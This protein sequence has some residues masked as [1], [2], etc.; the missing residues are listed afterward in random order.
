MKT[1]KGGLII[2]SGGC[3]ALVWRYAWANFV[4]VA[5]FHRPFPLF[6]AIVAFG[7]AAI[8][9]SVSRGRGWR[10][11]QVL[12]LQLTGF[13]LA[14]L[15][16]VYGFHEW[17]HP[18]TGTDWLLECLHSTRGPQEWLSLVLLLCWTFL[19]WFGGVSLAKKPKAYLAV[20]ARFDVGV[21][22][23]FALFLTKLL[24]RF[25]GGPA[26]EEPLSEIMLLP[27]FLFGLLAIGLARSQSL[28]QRGFL[29]GYRGLGVALS[30][31]A[32]VLLFGAG[33]VLLFYPYLTVAAEAG[34]GVLKVAARPMVPVLV[35]ILRFLFTPRYHS[36]SSSGAD[37]PASG[38]ATDPGWWAGPTGEVVRILLL[39]SAVLALLA[40][41]CLLLW[42]LFKWLLS[43]TPAR[44]GRSGG[45]S[46][47]SRLAEIWETI[48]G[49][50]RAV[51]G[52]M[53]NRRKGSVQ[54]YAAM[55]GWGRRSGVP[56]FLSETP[57]EYGGRLT[58]R[59]PDLGRDIA[60]IVEVFNREVYGGRKAEGQMLAPAQRAWAHLQSPLHWPHRFKAWFLQA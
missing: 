3:V 17:S 24:I 11:I 53:G 26:I 60:S 29:S 52:R 33:L 56:R 35:G 31:S 32:V 4:T 38:V 44:K 57:M 14:F 5:A 55:L 18:F 27:F 34:Y 6:E 30:F 58:Q 28:A 49:F 36:D 2:L 22:F 59:F 13:L 21:V 40:P 43:R 45:M 46:L 48:S 25:K 23:L 8:L 9:T 51:I 10:I 16:I 1:S 37:M 42:F 39:C 20:C 7:L 15:R 50:F 41:A 54:L 12:A 19:F 47:F